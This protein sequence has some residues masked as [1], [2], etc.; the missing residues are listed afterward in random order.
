MDAKKILQ[1]IPNVSPKK[2]ITVSIDGKLLEEFKSICKDKILSQVVEAII[3]DFVESAR[4]NNN[5]AN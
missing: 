2:N 1:G 5:Q 4:N 3:R